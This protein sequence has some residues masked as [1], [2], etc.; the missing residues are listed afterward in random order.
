MRR[1]GAEFDRHSVTPTFSVPSE[2]R[3][4]VR[5]EMTSASGRPRVC[6]HMHVQTS[7][8]ST[9]VSQTTCEG[10]T[11]T[12]VGTSHKDFLARLTGT[13]LPCCEA[14][15]T[16]SCG[17]SLADL[18]RGPVLSLTQ[19]EFLRACHAFSVSSRI[20]CNSNHYPLGLPRAWWAR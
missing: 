19:E 5:E 7:T 6:H 11:M 16:T 3:D 4:A 1:K 9:G 17:T 20:K 10:V 2:R 18:Q 14:A 15:A 13:N 12:P 8:E